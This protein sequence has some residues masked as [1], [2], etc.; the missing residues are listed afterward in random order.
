LVFTL[1]SNLLGSDSDEKLAGKVDAVGAFERP[2]LPL[3]FRPC[4]FAR[5]IC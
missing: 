4:L 5:V 1:D 2:E 3:D